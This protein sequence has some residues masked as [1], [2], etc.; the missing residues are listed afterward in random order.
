MPYYRARDVEVFWS[1]EDSLVGIST[2][3]VTSLSVASWS[4]AASLVSNF[5]VPPLKTDSAWNGTE[6]D[7]AGTDPSR[8][9]AVMDLISLDITP[10][11]EREDVDFLGRVVQDHITVRKTIEMVISKKMDTNEYA[12]VTDIA[13]A[14]VTGSDGVQ[15]INEAL[16]QTA[17]NSGFRLFAKISPT[18]GSNEMWITGRNMTLVEHKIVPAAAK[19]TEEQLTF[20]G[21]VWELRGVPYITPTTE[22]EL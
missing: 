10:T 15:G 19:A 20:R 7:A 11:K 14:G 2:S 9:K 1:T 8:A 4:D 18:T 17:T 5:V 21:N 22:I 6:T 13:D 16:D 12:L 3:G